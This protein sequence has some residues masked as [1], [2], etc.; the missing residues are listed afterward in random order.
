HLG[1]E[2]GCRRAAL[3]F[4]EVDGTV[5]SACLVVALAVPVLGPKVLSDRRIPAKPEVSIYLPVSLDRAMV[6]VQRTLLS[7]GV[8]SGIEQAVP[9]SDPGLIGTPPAGGRLT[10][11]GKSV[12]EALD[13]FVA[14]DPRY[15]WSES[16]GKV[17]LRP[18]T[19]NDSNDLLRKQLSI[20]LHHA[21]LLEA[22]RQI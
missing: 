20:D 4:P 1:G 18:R 13:A 19:R 9:E 16:N 14:L 3:H 17:L 22:L 15:R 2:A 5:V 8:A 12:R 11:S 21:T 10:L 7:A 6:Q